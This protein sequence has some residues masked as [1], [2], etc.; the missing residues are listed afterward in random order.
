MSDDFLSQEELE[1]QFKD[2]TA[3]VQGTA[4]LLMTGYN[5]VEGEAESDLF[6]VTGAATPTPAKT[7]LVLK[8]FLTGDE[9]KLTI[10]NL[11]LQKEEENTN[12]K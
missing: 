12:G 6:E 10:E 2:A 9:Y 8:H 5:E 1:R 7:V 11:S 4:R 3:T